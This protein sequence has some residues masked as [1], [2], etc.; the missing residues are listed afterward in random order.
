MINSTDKYENQTMISFT[1]KETNIVLIRRTTKDNVLIR[2]LQRIKPLYIKSA[3]KKLGSN[4]DRIGRN[5][6]DHRSA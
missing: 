6:F 1:L 2:K 3:K 4:W 5:A